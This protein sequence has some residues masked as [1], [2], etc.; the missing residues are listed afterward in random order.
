MNTL[1]LLMRKTP[2]SSFTKDLKRQISSFGEAGWEGLQAR[3][4]EEI[5]SHGLSQS[6]KMAKAL[7]FPKNEGTLL[8]VNGLTRTQARFASL[9]NSAQAAKQT[10]TSS[11]V[12]LGLSP[13]S[14]GDAVLNAITSVSTPSLKTF[15][16]PVLSYE[17]RLFLR[18]GNS[19]LVERTLFKLSNP[20]K[21][22]GLR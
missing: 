13:N 8:W 16:Q 14:E 4:S 1:N 15:S 18:S 9:A 21:R 19:G 11:S 6:K 12:L 2:I 5:I 10:H 20:L 22:K 3:T 17:S 7:T